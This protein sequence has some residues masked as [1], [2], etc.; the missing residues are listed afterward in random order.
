MFEI[1]TFKRNKIGHKNLTGVDR[2]R[3]INLTK[4]CILTIGLL[5]TLTLIGCSKED[6]SS[7]SISDQS[8]SVSKSETES[9]PKLLPLCEPTDNLVAYFETKDHWVN[10]CG[11][12]NQ[13]NVARIPYSSKR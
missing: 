4:S 7:S 11:Q 10:I 13:R 2:K 1:K 9:K 6:N 12:G 5:A 3:K 8:P